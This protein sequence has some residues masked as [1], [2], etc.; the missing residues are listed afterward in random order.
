RTHMLQTNTPQA[1]TPQMR[2]PQTHTPRMHTPQAHPP[3]TAASPPPRRGR[4]RTM[5]TGAKRG[6]LRS[7][8]WM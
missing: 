5:G 3:R 8:I 2:T 4:S 1:H 7:M 6:Q